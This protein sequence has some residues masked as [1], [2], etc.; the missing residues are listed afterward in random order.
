MLSSKI[1]LFSASISILKCT[2]D[3]RVAT[4]AAI[5][6]CCNYTVES[7]VALALS[8]SSP[9][10]CL[11]AR[12]ARRTHHLIFYNSTDQSTVVKV[13]SSGDTAEACITVSISANQKLLFTSGRKTELACL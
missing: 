5:L 13:S 9:S 1:F 12:G 4:K 2:I 6:V 8:L 3:R 11:E 10:P 7:E